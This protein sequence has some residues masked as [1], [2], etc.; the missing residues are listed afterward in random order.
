MPRP[1]LTLLVLA[2]LAP[3]LFGSVH[4]QDAEEDDALTA[5]DGWRSAAAFNLN[6]SQAAYRNWQE[7]GLDA[8][9]V[10]AETKGQFARVFGQFKQTHDARFALGLVKQD[11]LD[12]RK[13]LDVIRYGFNLQYLAVGA[14]RPTVATEI[15]T[16]FAPGFDYDPSAEEYP[17]LADRIR[18]NEELKV[19]DFFAPA[20]WTQT[21]GLTYDPDRW[22]TLRF[23]FAA[24]ETIVAIERLRP[25]YGNALDEGVRFEAGLDALAEVRRELVE[26][27]LFESRLGLFQGFGAFDDGPDATWENVLTLKVNDFLNANVAVDALLDRDVTEDIQLREAISVGLAFVLL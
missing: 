24:K 3:A 7:G 6:L 26:N 23:G 4:A 22:Y 18:P 12:F 27:V 16:Q 15:R 21:V 9:A 13:A 2:L 8:L 1:L 5:A 11:T 14:L 17:A 25:V 20:L 10:T 19:A